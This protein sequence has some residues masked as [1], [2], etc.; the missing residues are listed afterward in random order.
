MTTDT[1]KTL[2]YKISE[3][4]EKIKLMEI[5][6]K[7]AVEEKE[8]MLKENNKKISA[9]KDSIVNLENNVSSL[10]NET[11]EKSKKINSL[12][13]DLVDANKN[14]HGAKSKYEA[15]SERLERD[16]NY[17]NVNYK[18]LFLSLYQLLIINGYNIKNRIFII[19][20]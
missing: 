13:A 11:S 6:N 18:N 16:F 3:Y 12:E 4:E 8:I 20:L 14:A 1:Q 17:K 9:L 19:K 5:L 15:L 10:K 2:A 7:K